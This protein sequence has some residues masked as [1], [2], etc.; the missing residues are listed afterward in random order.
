MN[1]DY[2]G[3]ARDLALDFAGGSDAFNDT[4]ANEQTAVRDDREIEHLRPNARPGRTSQ[5]D[6]LRCVKKGDRLQD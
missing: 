2:F 4:L 6:Q 3:V 1:V 5:R